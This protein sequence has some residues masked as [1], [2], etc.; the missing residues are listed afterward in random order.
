MN[1]LQVEYFITLAACRN[2]SE[3]ARRLFVSQPTVSKQIAA[4]ESELGFKLL[5]RD[6]NT[7]NLTLEGSIMLEFFEK[8]KQ[9]YSYYIN[10]VNSICDVRSS[11]LKV[12]FLEGVGISNMLS[13]CFIELQTERSGIDIDFEFMKHTNLNQA[14]KNNEVDIA[15]TLED[16]IKTDKSI[17]S[18]VVA[19]IQ[20]GIVVN[21]NH[22]LAQ[23]EK[24]NPNLINKSKFFVTNSGSRG[25][26]N[27]IK[28]LSEKINL[29]TDNIVLVPDIET[30]LLNVEAGLGI[31]AMG[32]TSYVMKNE[33][34]KFYPIE[35]MKMSFVA[36]W[37]KANNN[38][39]KELLKKILK[40][41]TMIR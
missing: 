10:R 28:D 17:E 20:H 12:A 38:Q 34:L 21:K 14:L 4:L 19:N 37:N 13:D 29:N 11:K 8:T 7:V 18:I 39:S 31:S 25:Y 15:F 24:L 5:N 2:Y 3:T 9:Q 23:N 1:S 35:G 27:Y 6:N 32:Y 41:K 26:K 30:Q 36:A 40:N 22:K 16:E 33:E